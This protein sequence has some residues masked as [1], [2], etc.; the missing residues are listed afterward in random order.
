VGGRLPGEARDQ[1]VRMTMSGVRVIAEG[2]IHLAPSDSTGL[3]ATVGAGLDLTFL[4]VD[5]VPGSVVI[6]APSRSLVLPIVTGSVGLQQRIAGG[7]VVAAGASIDLD[8]TDARFVIDA[9]ADRPTVADPW[10]L[11]P[12]LWTAVAV[13]LE[14]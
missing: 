9:G 2:G 1:R 12:A 4:S 10:R 14:P 6:P 5:Q 13:E 8:V 7:L 3:F 11:R